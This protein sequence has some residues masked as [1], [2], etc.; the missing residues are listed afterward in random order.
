[1][2]AAILPL[3]A[4]LC[5]AVSYT[6]TADGS[7]T[8][9]SLETQAAIKA[10]P[11][12]QR[13]RSSN[14]DYRR[15]LI[16]SYSVEARGNHGTDS[17]P[18]AVPNTMILQFESD[19]SDSEI[20][21]YIES[22]NLIIV[23]TFP[24]IG[25]I[26]V[27]VD[28][29]P[30][31]VRSELADVN[32]NQALIRGLIQSIEKFQN[33]PLIRHASPDLVISN[34]D[35]YEANSVQRK[36]NLSNAATPTEEID[37]GIFDIEAD[38]LWN[39]PEA[40]DGTLFG[41]MDSGFAR[42]ED[43]VFLELRPGEVVSDH[44][45]HVAAIACGLHNDRGYRG[46]LPNCFVQ[47]RTTDVFYDDPSKGFAN[48]Y[49]IFSQIIGTLT[50]FIGS[51]PDVPT[52]NVS[53]GYNWHKHG[54]NPDLPESEDY[55]TLVAAQ[56]AILVS[57]LELAN[58]NDQVIFSAAGNDSAGH[59][60]P[61]T[62]KF[63]SPFNWAAVTAQ[64]QGIATNGVVV[65]AHDETGHRAEFS[66]IGGHLSCPGVG[67]SSAVARDAN[68]ESSG[69]SYGELSGTSMASPYCA[70]G[71]LLF[72]LVRPGYSGIE[73]V[74]CLRHS[75]HQSRSSGTPML[76]LTD[77][78]DACPPKGTVREPA[79]SPDSRF[80]PDPEPQLPPKSKKNEWKAVTG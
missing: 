8:L 78:L 55:R 33:D 45:N 34:E 79:D 19:V 21:N 25:A 68:G 52:F 27:E 48:F 57:V 69:S 24:E 70:A 46:V 73:A 58:K 17:V 26:Q 77:A 40:R 2:K 71:H 44:G 15:L 6:V 76:R 20:R 10:L 65:E 75:S 43:V 61:I 3:A 63:A 66:N 32:S 14:L 50:E 28:L 67:I 29:S 59:E 38:Q 72:R 51:Q 74:G 37:W 80:E 11:T 35:P 41:V 56:G 9:P 31:F 53:L 1:M 39:F 18:F 16:D 5:T 42:H 23:K 13:T 22:N 64:E 30:T 12:V 36:F 47:P 54:I 49:I 62:A 4:A 7:S 60:E